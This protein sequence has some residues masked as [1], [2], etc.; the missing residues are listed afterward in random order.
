MTSKSNIHT[1]SSRPESFSDDKDTVLSGSPRNLVVYKRERS[2]NVTSKTTLPTPAVASTRPEPDLAELTAQYL[3]SLHVADFGDFVPP[4][5][6][7]KAPMELDSEGCDNEETGSDTR[8]IST[9]PEAHAPEPEGMVDRTNTEDSSYDSVPVETEE[10]RLRAH[11]RGIPS[12]KQ[13]RDVLK[14][15]SKLYKASGPEDK[16]RGASM[17]DVDVEAESPA[18]V[19]T[20]RSS[21]SSSSSCS[22]SSCSSSSSSSSCSYSCSWETEVSVI[23][24]WQGLYI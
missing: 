13:V 7:D 14:Y 18:D 11:F 3:A 1:V 6:P 8:N 5:G 12:M 17:E 16:D 9:S 4:Y 2:Q 23:S 22:S 10:E 15:L 20:E 24:Y 21:G 19:N